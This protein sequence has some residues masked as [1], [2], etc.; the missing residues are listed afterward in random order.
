M[1]N[2]NALLEKEVS[3]VNNL[4]LSSF[5][6]KFNEEI[7]S[8]EKTSPILEK[9]LNIC[10]SKLEECL[11]NFGLKLKYFAEN[12]NF[13]HPSVQSMVTFLSD[14]GFTNKIYE[15]LEIHENIKDFNVS[16]I[17]QVLR[18]S[19]YTSDFFYKFNNIFNE[20]TPIRAILDKDLREEIR[21]KTKL[22]N[23]SGDIWFS[24]IE[25]N[26]TD[27]THSPDSLG[28]FA[29]GV[30]S[31]DEDLEQYRFV[32]DK[33]LYMGLEDQRA[34]FI[35][36][37]QNVLLSRECYC[38]FNKLESR[39]IASTLSKLHGFVPAE[40]GISLFLNKNFDL[41]KFLLQNIYLSCEIINDIF[42]YANE[43]GEVDKPTTFFESL[44]N[45][46]FTGNWEELIKS[47][48][49]Q[50]P[51]FNYRAR[52]YS[53]SNYLIRNLIPNNTLNVID[54]LDNFYDYGNFPIFD[55]VFLMVPSIAVG[56]S[57][58]TEKG[59][60]IKDDGGLKKFE[61]RQDAA[62]FLD[63]LLIKNNLVF[64][65]IVGQKDNKYY[66]ICYLD[67][68]DLSIK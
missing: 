56:E 36:Y 26:F 38:G 41:I 12:F 6:E 33:L 51:L 54:Q 37:I 46:N 59:F 50:F 29:R 34:S 63:L 7:V 58:H 1:Y 35:N 28:E 32:L 20:C 55:H 27:W 21:R 15:A 4:F 47:Y 25:I 64:P 60:F 65:L 2:K 45:V 18:D 9:I 3:S 16:N 31:L 39:L 49:K 14:P 52:C 42:N 53:V 24:E 5:N 68:T 67:K 62:L 43:D 8:P 17:F 48:F 13:K 44:N 61:R 40:S 57:I 22:T 30:N 19:I 23:K 10:D 11:G 66:P